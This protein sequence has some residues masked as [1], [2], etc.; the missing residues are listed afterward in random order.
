MLAFGAGN[1]RNGRITFKQDP[2][3]A[4]APVPTALAAQ[5]ELNGLRMGKNV[6]IAVAKACVSI[7]WGVLSG[8]ADGHALELVRTGIGV[9]PCLE[10][11]NPLDSPE[12]AGQYGR[13]FRKSSGGMHVANT[14]FFEAMWPGPEFRILVGRSCR[15]FLVGQA[16]ADSFCEWAKAIDPDS[17]RRSFR[18]RLCH[19]WFSYEHHGTVC[20]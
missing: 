16:A 8:E 13:D 11:K 7:Q 15:G 1:R 2:I 5:I 17:G 12:P 10:R 20:R 3:F 4:A 19:Q 18:D 9:K 14:R 6:Q